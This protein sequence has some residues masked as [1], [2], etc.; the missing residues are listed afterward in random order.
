MPRRRTTEKAKRLALA[1]LRNRRMSSS[2]RIG[3][4]VGR[5]H[6]KCKLALQVRADPKPS[7][8]RL[9]TGRNRDES[10]ASEAHPQRHEKVLEVTSAC[11]MLGRWPEGNAV[12]IDVRER[13]I[14]GRTSLTGGRTPH[15][16]GRT[17]ALNL[18]VAN[19]RAKIVGD[20]LLNEGFKVE[21]KEWLSE[22]DLQRPYLDDV[23]PGMDQ[24]ALNRTVFIELKSAGACDL[25]R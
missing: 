8:W 6:P 19:L 5:K 14:F 22:N 24:Q 15:Q 12:H 17:D 20:H 11:G 21:I 18:G 4:I 16:L 1:Y 9:R 23:Q 7:F 13:D 2:L 25:A 3:G 10:L